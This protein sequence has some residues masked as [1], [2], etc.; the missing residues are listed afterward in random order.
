MK[1]GLYK[2]HA[3]VLNSTDYGE[4]DRIL[5]FFTKECGKISGIAKGAR[6]SRKRFVGNLDPLSHIKFNY[7]YGGGELVRVEDASLIEGFQNLRTDIERLSNACYLLELVSEMTREGQ[8][9]PD[10]YNMLAGFLRMMD[11]GACPDDSLLRFFEIRLLAALGFM[12]CIDRCVVCGA[13]LDGLANGEWRL[14]GFSSEKGGIVC[15][16]CPAGGLA[17]LSLGTARLLSTAAK[18]DGEKLTR[19]VAG[20]AFARESERILYDFIKF[21]IG[22]ELKTKKFMH[23]LKNAAL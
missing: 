16:G 21:Q 19:L 2:G 18:L 14:K 9:L 8:A 11:N 15:G 13:P 3:V 6:R 1:K 23:K 10:V 4:S 7:F 17:P 20:P 5:S 22:K 12:P